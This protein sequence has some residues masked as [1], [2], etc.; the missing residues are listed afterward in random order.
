MYQPTAHSTGFKRAATT[1]AVAPLSHVEERLGELELVE[2]KSDTEDTSHEPVQ[3][4]DDREDEEFAGI[5]YTALPGSPGTE[6]EEAHESSSQRT[7]VQANCGSSPHS[8][9]STLGNLPSS[10]SEYEGDLE[11]ESYTDTLGTS[12]NDSFPTETVHKPL[13]DLIFKANKEVYDVDSNKVRM[14]VGLSKRVPSLHPR[15]NINGAS[16]LQ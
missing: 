10:S 1:S 7:E 11:D 4:L 13:K 3:C 14:K 2:T 8:N 16:S 9:N 5:K 15:R 12:A 6:Q